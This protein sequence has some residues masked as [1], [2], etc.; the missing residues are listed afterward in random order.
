[1][2]LVSVVDTF[3]DHGTE[4]EKRNAA[5]I[6]TYFNLVKIADTSKLLTKPD[7]SMLP[8]LLE[9]VVF[10]H[11]EANS[12]KIS[13]DDMPNVLFYRLDGLMKPTP[14]LRQIFETI[15]IRLAKHSQT[16]QVAQYHKGFYDKIFFE[17]RK[18]FKSKEC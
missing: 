4:T 17:N 7:K 6:S 14:H 3:I 10:M 9:D 1:M 5:I 8:R 12:L 15:K 2:W 18:N 16:M 11:D 13:S